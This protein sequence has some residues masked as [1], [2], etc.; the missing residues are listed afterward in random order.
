[1][2][3]AHCEADGLT[4]AHCEADGFEGAHCKVNGLT[5]AVSG[6]ALMCAGIPIDNT[7]K[8]YESVQFHIRLHKN[9]EEEI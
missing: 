4:D 7:L 3:D 6:R 1:M 5:G 2:T 9:E 8:E